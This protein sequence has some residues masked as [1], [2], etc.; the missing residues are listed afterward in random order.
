LT[1]KYT[2]YHRGD[3]ESDLD[4]AVPFLDQEADLVEDQEE[5]FGEVD[6]TH[7]TMGKHQPKMT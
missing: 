3:D 4:E 2:N 7:G 1:T 5:D 6:D